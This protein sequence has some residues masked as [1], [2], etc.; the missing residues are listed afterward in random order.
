[1]TPMVVD[2]SSD[3]VGLLSEWTIMVPLVMLGLAP[4]LLGG[5]GLLIVWTNGFT[6]IP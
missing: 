6:G 5:V 4:W 1:M 3:N 2:G